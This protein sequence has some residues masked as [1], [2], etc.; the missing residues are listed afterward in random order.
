MRPG[1]P[2][3]RTHDYRRNGL[4]SL[5]AA[6]NTASGEVVGACHARHTAVEFLAFL[7]VLGPARRTV[8]DSFVTLLDC[9]T[10]VLPAPPAASWRS[11]DDPNDHRRDI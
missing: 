8:D 5:Y 11:D 2:E 7:R 1:L 3:R 6:F 9:N 4:T 10:R